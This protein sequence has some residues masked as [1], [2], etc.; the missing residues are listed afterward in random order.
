MQ[1]HV[2]DRE[3]GFKESK[4]FAVLCKRRRISNGA[5]LN[6]RADRIDK[7]RGRKLAFASME[8]Q[9]EDLE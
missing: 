1:W 8:M 2:K 4:R 3:K 6:N 9:M 7:G 5:I